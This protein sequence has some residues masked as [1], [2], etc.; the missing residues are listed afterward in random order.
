[1]KTRGQQYMIAPSSECRQSEV[2]LRDVT[3]NQHASTST[4]TWVL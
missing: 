3:S 2:T 4:S 1:M